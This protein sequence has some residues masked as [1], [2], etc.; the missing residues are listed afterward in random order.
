MTKGFSKD[1]VGST[2]IEYAIVLSLVSL[3]FLG[4]MSAVGGDVVGFFADTADELSRIA[5][6]L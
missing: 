2:V 5:A 3:G 6:Q 1:E 4:A